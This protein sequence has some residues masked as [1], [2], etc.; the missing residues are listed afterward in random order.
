MGALEIWDH[1]DKR[2]VGVDENHPVPCVTLDHGHYEIHTAQHWTAQDVG[3]I[4][5]G[6]NLDLLFTTPAANYMHALIY[7]QTSGA[8]TVQ[9][10]EAATGGTAAAG[11][12]V[13]PKNRNRIS[14]AAAAMTCKRDQTITGTGTLLD[15][16]TMGGGVGVNGVGANA[17]A[18][19]EWI[20]KQSTP[21]L[22][23]ITSG[24]N[25]N[26]CVAGMDFYLEEP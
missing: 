21:Y 11:T 17:R 23:R 16:R 7:A 2:Y 22:L 15:F 18:D 24:T 25:G 12:T 5:S 3:T 10:F 9:F 20:L 4:A 13:T 14:D 1:D 6:A 19:N 8:G 26:V